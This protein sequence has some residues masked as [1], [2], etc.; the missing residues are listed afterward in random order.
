[1]CGFLCIFGPG[2]DQT[3]K[4]RFKNLTEALN[5]RGP[6]DF[7]ISSGKNYSTYFWRLS[8]VDR[9]FGKQPMKSYDQTVTLLFNGE[10]YNYLDIRNQLSEDYKFRTKSDTETIIAAYKKWGKECFDYFEGMFS[11]V[12]IDHKKNRIILSRDLA[13]V[14][15]MYYFFDGKNLFISSEYKVFLKSN[16]IEKKIDQEALKKYIIF[17]TIPGKSNLVKGI[18]KLIPGE[19]IEFDLGTCEKISSCQIKLKKYPKFKSYSEYYECLEEEIFY[20]MKIATNTDL[21]TGYH[22]SGGLDS[23]TLVSLTKKIRKDKNFFFVSSIIDDES[24]HEYEY[25]R[26]AA[27]IYQNDLNIVNIN[28]KSFFDV[29]DQVISFLDEP[30]GDP[31]VIPQYLVNEEISKQAKIVYSGQGFDEFFFG[32]ARNL[33][34]YSSEKYGL[35]SF[36]DAGPNLPKDIN[37]FFIGWD[38]FRKELKNL[39]NPNAKMINYVKLCRFNPFTFN[40]ELNTSFMNDLKQT[41]QDIFDDIDQISTSFSSFMYNSEVQIQLPSLL[42][43]EDRVSMAHSV[44]TRVPFCTNSIMSL[45]QKGNLE[46]KFYNNKTKGII[47]EISKNLIPD[48]ILNRKKKIGRPVPFRKWFLQNKDFIHTLKDMTVEIEDIYRSKGI[49]D[50]AINNKNPFD[51]TLWGIWSLMKWKEI[52]KISY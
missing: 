52:Y 38:D 19:I 45:A 12:I 28:S 2:C 4:F 32:Y 31:G 23:N 30:V 34:A 8:I 21:A 40:P 17:Q 5:H 36:I 51:R 39:D 50:Y 11:I 33:A 15:P 46:W 25:I 49:I 13:G 48:I 43:M 3:E 6:D 7:G 27:S 9:E 47:R 20:Q 41:A 22:L 24:D 29:F 10:I 35:S 26:E 18:N 14:K 42:H 1:M 16:I 44:E 37:E